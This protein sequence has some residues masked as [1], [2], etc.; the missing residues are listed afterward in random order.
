[1]PRFDALSPRNSPLAWTGL[2]LSFIAALLLIFA[3]LGTR[4][5]LWHFRTGFDLLRWGAYVG[6]VALLVCLLAALFAQRQPGRGGA[7]ALAVVGLII[8]AFCVGLPWRWQRTARAAPPIHDIT[9]N[10]DNPPAFVAVV[11]LR[12]GAPNS[13]EYGGPEVAA[14]QRAAYPDIR[15]L[16]LDVPKERAF[17]LALD[18]VMTERWKLVASDTA[19]GRI[20]ATARTPWFGFYDDVVV[21]LTPIDPERTVV[22]VRSV[23]RV[24]RGDAGTNANRVRGFLDLMRSAA[25]G[26]S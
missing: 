11:P 14:L 26:R 10:T 2:V 4:W 5:G 17:A 24:G 15:P 16:V 22:D 13:L 8:A 12:A 25:A 9:T 23:S 1:M 7:L 21:R 19:A 6:I 20:E 3:G 18:A